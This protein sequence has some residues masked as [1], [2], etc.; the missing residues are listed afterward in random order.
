MPFKS[1]KSSE[2]LVIWHEKALR[3]RHCYEFVE[4]VGGFPRAS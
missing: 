4:T 3:S 2:P 1:R